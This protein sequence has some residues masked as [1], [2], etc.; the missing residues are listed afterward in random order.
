M[1]LYNRFGKSRFN[2]RR[3]RKADVV[4]AVTNFI[5]YYNEVR[6]KRD[7]GWLSPIEYREANPKGTLPVPMDI[8][9]S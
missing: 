5:P 4:E 6:L 7:L 3:I 2:S 9:R 1:L 8:D